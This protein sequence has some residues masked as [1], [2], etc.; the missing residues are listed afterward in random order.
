MERVF[1]CA[2]A[3]RMFDLKHI[4][5]AQAVLDGNFPTVKSPNPEEVEAMTMALTSQS[6]RCGYYF[7]YRP[8][9]R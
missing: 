8:R 2:E 6:N 3:L 7:S 5:A 4:L 9:C 1:I